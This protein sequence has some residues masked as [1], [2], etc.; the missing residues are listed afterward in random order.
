MAIASAMAPK[1]PQKI[2]NITVSLFFHLYNPIKN[3]IIKII[4]SKMASFQ[5][6]QTEVK[7]AKA[8]E[9]LKIIFLIF[10]IFSL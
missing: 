4:K 2:N 1:I 7:Q 3:I 6:K 9:T 8:N 10:I 5:K